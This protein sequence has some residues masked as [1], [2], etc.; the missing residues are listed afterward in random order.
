M[1]HKIQKLEAKLADKEKK[2]QEVE[3]APNMPD[4]RSFIVEYGL[5]RGEE[6]QIF[7]TVDKKKKNEISSDWGEF[8]G[9]F[10]ESFKA[11]D[12]DKSHYIDQSEF[13]SCFKHEEWK[14]FNDAAAE[15]EIEVA[16]DLVDIIS[17]GKKKINFADYLV[18][19]RSQVAWE[20]CADKQGLAKLRFQCAV[21]I[22]LPYDVSYDEGEMGDL[23]ETA[24]LIN[25][26]RLKNY[27]FLDIPSFVDFIHIYTY[28]ND[29]DVALTDGF[30]T[31]E[32][33]LRGIQAQVLPVSLNNRH[34]D[35]M[36]E[37]V[38]SKGM[39]ASTFVCVWDTFELLMA[40]DDDGNG[41]INP[42]EFM[43][44]LAHKNTDK[45]LLSH[46]DG[47]YMTSQQEIKEE[48]KKSTKNTVSEKSFIL[49][50][51]E[52][53]ASTGK[54]GKKRQD[55]I[56]VSPEEAQKRKM[57]YFIFDSFEK[58]RM[59][60]GDMVLFRKL[61]WNFVGYAYVKKFLIGVEMKA[62][63]EEFNH[64]IPYTTKE[65]TILNDI[66]LFLSNYLIINIKEFF[67]FFAAPRMFE[68]Y[69]I[70]GSP[71][72]VSEEAIKLV[73]SHQGIKYTDTT[74]SEAREFFRAGREKVQFNSKVATR[75]ALFYECNVIRSKRLFELKIK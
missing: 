2:A 32:E 21:Q 16:L 23:F 46:I 35:T 59:T 51:L 45:I 50:F 9:L 47:I 48:S 55:I 26:G 5:S 74:I 11:C 29:F 4:F 1:L 38:D 54:H 71:E 17:R 30:L 58:E 40:F 70:P 57:V 53:K 7:H 68:K 22:A 63:S 69:K 10:V 49:N 3:D 73:F 65:K 60:L 8:Y 43:H 66:I 36:F 15:D 18:I 44:L 19:R 41:Y 52:V 37:V 33:F 39:T 12:K 67:N 61:A 24:V 6:R 27:L 75:A 14:V 28:F 13:E 42:I 25:K 20:R 56:R 64:P 31:K 62:E 34:A 72:F